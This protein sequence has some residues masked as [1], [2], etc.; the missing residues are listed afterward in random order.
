ML[1]ASVC[2]YAI[3]YLAAIP[4][5]LCG[6][7]LCLHCDCGVCLFCNESIRLITNIYSVSHFE[8]ALCVCTFAFTSTPECNDRKNP[9][10][11]E[12]G[13]HSSR[14]S[15]C[16]RNAKEKMNLNAVSKFPLT[17]ATVCSARATTYNLICVRCTHWSAGSFFLLTTCC[18]LC[19]GK[20]S[21]HFCS[22]VVGHIY[23]SRDL[24][25][26]PTSYRLVLCIYYFHFMPP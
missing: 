13:S 7:F 15:L 25:F 26:A 22:F 10:L 23:I 24:S 9:L 1:C 17:V 20:R 4:L 14:E 16:V 5:R 2:I 19:S 6:A 8:Y 12:R 21:I 11:R 18:R 3:G